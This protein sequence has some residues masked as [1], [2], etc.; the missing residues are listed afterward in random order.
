MPSHKPAPVAVVEVVFV[1][2][3]AAAN[4]ANHPRAQDPCRIVQEQTQLGE[5][6][7]FVYFL[8]PIGITLLRD[9]DK[10]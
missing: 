2:L 8:D 4:K 6:Y 10:N 7:A 5:L 3:A 9:I 1:E